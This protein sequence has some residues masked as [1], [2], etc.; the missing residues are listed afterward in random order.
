MLA[1]R[2]RAAAPFLEKAAAGLLAADAAAIFANV[3]FL[4]QAGGEIPRPQRYEDLAKKYGTVIWVYA[5]VSRKARDVASVPLKVVQRQDDGTVN[6]VSRDNE[7][8]QVLSL[9]NPFTTAADLVEST[10][11]NLDIS[12]NAYWLKFGDRQGIVR[13]LWA[14]RPDLVTILASPTDYIAGYRVRSGRREFD[15]TPDQVVHFREFNPFSDYY[16]L[17]ALTACYSSAIIEEEAQQWNRAMMRNA[18]R[19]DGML[20][21]DQVVNK[22]QALQAAS[23]FREAHAGARNA[24]RV[25]VMGKGLKYESVA[26]S[27]KELDFILSRKL[28]REEILAALGVRPV[29]LGLEAGDIGR[30]SEQI[31]DYFY[32]TVGARIGRIVAT[33]NEF[34]A[35]GY[36]YDGL[37]VIAEV[38]SALMPY[39]DRL[40]L[41]QADAA[42]VT[43]GI[44]A[45]NEVRRRLG[46]PSIAGG[47]AVLVPMTMVPLGTALTAA[48]GAIVPPGGPAIVSAPPAWRKDADPRGALW[49]AFVAKAT[50]HE[51]AMKTEVYRALLATGQHMQGLLES[52][53]HWATVA[54]DG[55]AAAQRMLVQVGRDQ[56][57]KAMEAGFRQAVGRVNDQL[58]QRAVRKE[59][60]TIGIDWSLSIPEIARYLDQRPVQYADQVVATL[61]PDI[62]AQLAD[63]V[64]QGASSAEMATA[65]TSYIEAIAP[66]KAA[67]IA[68]T[69]VIA[70]ANL[71]ATVAYAESGVVDQ[72]EWLSARNER[73]RVTHAVAD[74]EVVDLGAPFTVGGAQLDY[75][76]DPDG[77]AEE[78]VN[79]RCT[80][81]PVLTDQSGGA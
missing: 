37:E 69:E 15:F 27:P 49:D 67:V 41:A 36:G 68:R 39:E 42:Y 5:A 10:S 26:T 33:I 7:L 38:E 48:P 13:E 24:G 3:A 57:P 28:T 16:G 66:A 6:E 74:G 2:E 65:L 43:A 45:R 1:V 73:V 80:T 35:P 25:M 53:H 50:P 29:I 30:R 34:L 51:R 76:G 56:L 62:R 31:R 72:Q 71:A 54:T 58:T 78:T 8:R 17:G 32:A 63:Q 12:G 18:G 79:C 46:H 4:T 61:A 77:P 59:P 75:P 22:A 81:L 60:A 44:L 40:A 70:A 11:A 20:V 19:L 9:V 55:M 14:I 47:D 64:A 21:S 52:G 23:E